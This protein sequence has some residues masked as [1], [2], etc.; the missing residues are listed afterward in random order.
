MPGNALERKAVNDAVAYLRSLAE[1]RGRNAE[2]AESAVRE[3][4]SLSASEALKQ[5]VIDLIADDLPAL[6]AALDGRTAHAIRRHDAAHRRDS[7]AHRRAGLA[8]AAVV[9]DHEP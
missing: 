7:H 9:T 8:H 3:G 5:G 6:L 1:L 2:W 4:A